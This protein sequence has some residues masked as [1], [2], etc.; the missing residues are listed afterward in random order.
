MDRYSLVVIF[1]LIIAIPV[2]AQP[3]IN[4]DESID[5][6]KLEISVLLE[7]LDTSTQ[8][9]VPL[10]LDYLKEEF[11]HRDLLLV[12]TFYQKSPHHL[13]LRL[14]LGK[15]PVQNSYIYSG[16]VGST[17]L[18]ISDDY[19]SIVVKRQM[20]ASDGEFAEQILQRSCNY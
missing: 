2:L 14:G 19:C 16:A 1:Y 9:C 15:I 6:Y 10:S 8:Y 13:L 20:L 11:P 17:Y 12:E 5:P 4:F 7:Q 3:I 18:R